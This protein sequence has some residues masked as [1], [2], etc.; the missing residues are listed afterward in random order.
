MPED[1]GE[2]VPLFPLLAQLEESSLPRV[3]AHQ[4]DDEVVDLLVLT[5]SG[6]WDA[7]RLDQR[8]KLPSLT[9]PYPDGTVG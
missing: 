6:S 4:I 8:Q 2:V 5:L 1:Q 7:P 3:W 9:R